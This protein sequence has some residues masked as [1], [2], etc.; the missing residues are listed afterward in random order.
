MAF[1]GMVLEAQENDRSG[2][3]ALLAKHV[4]Q[5]NDHAVAKRAGVKKGDVVIEFNGMS[6]AMTEQELLT[7][8]L[9]NTRPGDV[10]PVKIKRGSNV[11][12]VKIKLQ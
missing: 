10:V 7:H 11:M 2:K 9:Q 5:Y 12:D 4:G 8:T 1:G 6:N 3:M